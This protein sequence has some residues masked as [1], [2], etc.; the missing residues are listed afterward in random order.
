MYNTIY[1]FLQLTC[2]NGKKTKK[3]FPKKTKAFF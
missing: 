1:I 2:P 3:Y